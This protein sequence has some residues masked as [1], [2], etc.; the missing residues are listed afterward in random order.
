MPYPK[1]VATGPDGTS[2]LVEVD[3]DVFT[4]GR[5]SENDLILD[6]PHQSRRRVEI[7]RRDRSYYLY[8]LGCRCAK[9]VNGVA[10]RSEAETE[11]VDGTSSRSATT[12]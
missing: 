4:I 9:Y 5:G 3:K 6:D 8:D 11:I 10:I 12:S 7:H 2:I 1:L